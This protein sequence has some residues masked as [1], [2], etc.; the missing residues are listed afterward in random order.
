MNKKIKNLLE[1]NGE[2]V[3]NLILKKTVLKEWK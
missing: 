2:S 3:K 1:E